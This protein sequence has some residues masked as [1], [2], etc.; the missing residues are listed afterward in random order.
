VFWELWTREEPFG[1]VPFA[2]VIHAVVRQ[3]KRPSLSSQDA[4]LM[5]LDLRTLI[6]ESWQ[7]QAAKRSNINVVL[8]RLKDLK[9]RQLES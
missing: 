7:Q 4:E 6:E 9:A 2:D 3:E 5:P 8:T 1:G